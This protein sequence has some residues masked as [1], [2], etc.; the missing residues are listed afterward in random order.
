MN[1]QMVFYLE[2]GEETAGKVLFLEEDHLLDK[3]NGVVLNSNRGTNQDRI[4]HLH[5]GNIAYS[6]TTYHMEVKN[7]F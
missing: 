6:Y 3:G 7:S 4:I 5:M 1:K 2:L